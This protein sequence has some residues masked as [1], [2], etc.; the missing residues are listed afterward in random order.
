MS[1]FDDAFSNKTISRSVRRV[2]VPP[3]PPSSIRLE[4]TGEFLAKPSVLVYFNTQRL[5]IRLENIG[6]FF[7]KPSVFLHLGT[8][9]L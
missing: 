2:G 9:L 3:P 6:E 5:L 4:N 8:A 7:A 1:I